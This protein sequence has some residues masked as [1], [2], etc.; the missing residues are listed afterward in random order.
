MKK[1]EISEDIYQYTFVEEKS[2]F[3]FN[4]I[5]VIDDKIA[6][7]IDPGYVIF[8]EQVKADLESQNIEVIGIL[9]SHHH[10]DHFAG[11][12]LFPDVKTFGSPGFDSDFQEHL[13]PNEYLNSFQPEVTFDKEKF[14]KTVKH[15]IKALRTPGHNKCAYSFHIN[16]KIL[17]VGDLIIYDKSGKPTIPYMDDNSTI[18]E[19]IYSL[20][21][22]KLL[23]P[24]ILIMGHGEPITNKNDILEAIDDRLYYLH[25]L[26]SIPFDDDIDD[27]LLTTSEEYA[28]LNFHEKNIKKIP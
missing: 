16:E 18:D 20:D 4:I 3:P 24:D 28:G 17:F 22:I 27:F 15:S 21:M 11:C 10:E 5:A 2:I 23:N 6:F 7:L 25:K 26:K 19:H 8:T 12:E 1:I 14:I 13:Q 9:I